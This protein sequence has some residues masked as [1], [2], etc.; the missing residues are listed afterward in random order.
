MALPD[1]NYLIYQ[2][3]ITV[4]HWG[5][6]AGFAGLFYRQ[7]KQTGI[8][9]GELWW[10]NPLQ[11]EEWVRLYNRKDCTQFV[12]VHRRRIQIE[13][14]IISASISRYCRLKI[15]GRNSSM[16]SEPEMTVVISN[17]TEVGIALTDDDITATPPGSFPGKLLAFLYH[18]YKI[19]NGDATKGMR[20]SLLI[21][22]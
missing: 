21:D 22:C 14:N 8:L 12:F 16:R 7:S 5:V 19:F 18:R 13:E 11:A 6:V 4:W 2:K 20:S 10:L 15:M 9:M 17:T 1:E 3:N